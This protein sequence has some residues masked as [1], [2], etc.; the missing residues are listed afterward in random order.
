VQTTEETPAFYLQLIVQQIRT[1]S[2][3]SELHSTLCYRVVPIASSKS[4]FIFEQHI[5]D[6][7]PRALT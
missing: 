4:L 3:E 6:R 5:S 1:Y 2:C 7:R